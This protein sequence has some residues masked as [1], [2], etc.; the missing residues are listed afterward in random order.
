MKIKYM[1]FINMMIE[2]EEVITIE[3]KKLHFKRQFGAHNVN[4]TF[5]LDDTMINDIKNV[6]I[7][8]TSLIE[9]E[10]I[11]LVD[12]VAFNFTNSSESYKQMCQSLSSLKFKY[13]PRALN[14]DCLFYLGDFP[15]FFVHHLYEDAINFINENNLTLIDNKVVINSEE[16]EIHLKD[17]KVISF[18]TENKLYQAIISTLVYNRYDF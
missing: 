18:N 2:Q 16:I 15:T 4:Q 1:P 11:I 13:N 14:I 9:F 3:N 10:D 5:V 7:N 8:E 12:D 6:V 17:Y